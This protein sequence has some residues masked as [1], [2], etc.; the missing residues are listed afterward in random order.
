MTSPSSISGVTLSGQE[1]KPP[2]GPKDKNGKILSPTFLGGAFPHL[3]PLRSIL[4]SRPRSSIHGGWILHP[5]FLRGAAGHPEV[6]ADGPGAARKKKISTRH[7]M[8]VAKTTMTPMGFDW[9]NYNERTLE[10]MVSKGNHPQMAELFRLVNYYNLPRFDHGTL[11]NKDFWLHP[12]RMQQEKLCKSQRP[13]MPE[14]DG[15]P[16]ECSSPVW[17]ARALYDVPDDIWLRYQMSNPDDFHRFSLH[18]LDVFWARYIALVDPCCANRE[19][20]KPEKAFLSQ[21]EKGGNYWQFGSR[22]MGGT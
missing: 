5:L 13:Q 22:L 15:I 6:P 1:K 3:G 4:G 7:G 14:W 19:R 8:F 21:R 2:S 16:G 10:I 20:S 12:R 17:I 9:V 11:L 18:N